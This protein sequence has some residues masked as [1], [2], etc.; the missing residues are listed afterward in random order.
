MKD[1]KCTAV[2]LWTLE[3]DNA[4]SCHYRDAGSRVLVLGS[5][6]TKRRKRGAKHAGYK[7]TLE[8]AVASRVNPT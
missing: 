3:V 1:K 7:N 2:L 4:I 5:E 8:D 6:E